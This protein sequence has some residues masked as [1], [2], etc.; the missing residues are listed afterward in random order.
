MPDTGLRAPRILVLDDQ[1]ANVS[2][3][4][5]ILR[6]AGHEHVAAFTDPVAAMAAFHADPPDLL[7]LDLHMPG[8]DGFSILQ[9]IA[10]RRAEGDFLPVMVM[11]GDVN[12]DTRRRAVDL[13]ADDFLTKPFDAEDVVLRTRNLLYTRRLYQALM[14][15]NAELVSAIETHAQGQGEERTHRALVAASLARL[16][17]GDSV[18]STATAICEAVVAAIAAPSASIVE[19]RLDGSIMVVASAGESA[20]L[21]PGRV[22][23]P[24]I[25]A[26][27]RER[28]MDG[29]WVAEPGTRGALSHEIDGVETT[30]VYAPIHVDGAA[31]AGLIVVDLGPGRRTEQLASR[32][33]DILEFAAIAAALLSPLLGAARGHAAA[34]DSIRQ[35]IDRRALRPVF[36]PIVRLSDQGVVGYE[37]LT[38]FAD[39]APPDRRFS[40]AVS[41]GMGPDL[42]VACLEQA[43]EASKALPTG[44]FLSLNISPELA[45]EHARLAALIRIPDRPI[46]LEITEHAP[47]NDYDALRASL[48]SF[49]PPVRVAIDDAGAGYASF[50]HIVE[51]QPDFVKLDIGLVRSLDQDAPRRALIGGIDYFAL[52]SGSRLIAEGVETPAERASLEELGVEL[53]QGYLLG[54]PASIG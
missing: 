14:I 54:R 20:A 1:I 2:L 29:L 22:V 17:P 23:A 12:L 47:I 45:L 33:A 49:D 36:Q 11:T 21:R 51:L 6:R 52:K 18:G 34:R 35:I 28:A 30:R 3:L 40:E 38:R 19:F 9:E 5:L 4:E 25:A 31:L 53:G 48:T 39:G 16:A 8:R 50:R 27:L 10:A 7:L 41:V 44:S 15:R 24:E 32:L 37:A 46:V 42:E 43:I 26:A 13:G